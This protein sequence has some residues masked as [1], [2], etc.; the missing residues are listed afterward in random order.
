M[1]PV[2]TSVNIDKPRAEVFEYLADIANHPEFLDHLF[3]DW[4]ML[5]T[6]TYGRGAGARFRSTK[7]NDRFGWG[8]L[9]VLELQRPHKILMVGR[10]GKYNRIET[11]AEWR[12]DEQGA[13]ATRVTW[14]FETAPPL[15]TDRNMETLSGRKGW[16]KRGSRKALK[17]LRA[18]QEEGPTTKRRGARATVAGR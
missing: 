16:F 10:G 1:D 5:R 18:I 15:P 8:E 2:S 6:D 9:N 12:L 17:R 4:R 11:F 13:D 14:T 7:R 3:K